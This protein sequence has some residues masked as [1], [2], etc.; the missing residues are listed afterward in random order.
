MKT[1][2]YYVFSI[3]YGTICFYEIKLDK[4]RIKLEVQSDETSHQSRVTQIVADAAD[5][6]SDDVTCVLACHR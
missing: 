6:I 5:L 4:E 1:M 3:M 2:P